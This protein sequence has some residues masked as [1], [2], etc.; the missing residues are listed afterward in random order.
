M[1][2]L[3]LALRRQ[4]GSRGAW[5]ARF[6]GERQAILEQVRGCSAETGARRVLIRRVAGLE[7]SSRFWSVWM[8]L[9][10]LRIVN[11]ALADLI[12]SLARGV[13]PDTVVSTAAVKPRPD[14]GDETIAAFEASCARLSAVVAAAPDLS[15]RGRLTHPWF[16]PLDAASWYVLAGVHMGVHRLQ[17]RRILAGMTSE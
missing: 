11:V 7:D 17:I 4:L 6:A 2:R 15:T 1:A 14:V 9:D 13:V 12:G 5:D 3:W 16:G 10:H 8:T